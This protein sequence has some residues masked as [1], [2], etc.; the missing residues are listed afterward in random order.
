MRLINVYG[1]HGTSQG[2][3]KYQFKLD[4]IS[5]LRK[6]FDKKFST[7]D[8]VLLCGDLNVAPHELDVWSVPAW[9]GKLHFTKAERDAIQ[10]VKK[11]GFVD[12]FRQING[13]EREFSG[14]SNFRNDF[15]KDRG[16]RI[17]HHVGIENGLL[18]RGFDDR[19]RHVALH[20][21]AALRGRSVGGV[22]RILAARVSRAHPVLVA[23]AERALARGIGGVG[24]AVLVLGLG[25]APGPGSPAGGQARV[26][27]SV[28]PSPR[29]AAWCA[30]TGVRGGRD[31]S[32][33]ATAPDRFPGSGVMTC[34]I[35]THREDRAAHADSDNAAAAAAAG[36][37]AGA[38]RQRMW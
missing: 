2:T 11:W 20:V 15:E 28:I 27:L 13:D 21:A 25:A 19:G 4:W 7:D 14:W 5:R 30:A 10:E 17:D 18:R 3:P 9:R 12:L 37:V 16:L 38:G 29:E 31:Q 8:D 6:Y 23:A 22:A 26:G 36:A 32:E 34:T 35:R 33:G 1:P 24:V